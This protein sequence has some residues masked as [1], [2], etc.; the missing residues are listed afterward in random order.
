M[1]NPSSRQESLGKAEKL[2][3]EILP[4]VE[5]VLAK[6]AREAGAASNL[7]EMTNIILEWLSVS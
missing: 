4:T 1:E 5:P 7:G 6:T 2:L 3:D